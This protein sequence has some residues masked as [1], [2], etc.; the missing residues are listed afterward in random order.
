VLAKFV[1]CF[2]AL[3]VHCALINRVIPSLNIRIVVCHFFC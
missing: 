1:V 3:H 2:C